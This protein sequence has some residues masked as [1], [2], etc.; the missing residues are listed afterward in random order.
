MSDELMKIVKT[1]L[2]THIA[3][4]P[5]MPKPKAV[6]S[7][8]GFAES[9]ID[10][11]VENE[12]DAMPTPQSNQEN[13]GAAKK[14]RGKTKPAASKFSKPKA[15]AP[16]RRASGGSVAVTKKAPPK[17]KAAPKRAPLNEQTN[18]RSLS[19]TEEVDE[20]D[21][22]VPQDPKRRE[23]A[24]ELL[25]VKQP[26]KRGRKPATRTTKQAELEPQQQAKIT[27][28]DGE[29]EY[30]PTVVRQTK[31]SKKVPLAARRPAVSK[32]QPSAEPRR[33]EVIPETQ[34]APMGVDTSLFPEEDHEDAMPQSVFRPTG[35][36]PTNPG[37]R[38]APIARRRAGS[39]SDTER[40]AS[41]P[42]IRRKL[43]DM[44]KKFENLD[45]KYRNLR[46]V[47][48]KEAEA[49]FERLK[50]TSEAKAKG[51]FFVPDDSY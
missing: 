30:T 48:I 13:A 26:A 1:N 25:P 16:S 14:G 39:A 38:Q 50:T 8:S 19:D 43:G 7:L 21:A 17:K 32:R 36:R 44:T 49:N 9:D 3:P 37:I 31:L 34:E 6:A 35:D 28:K 42:A 23:S 12:A 45:M 41:D 2:H 47:G 33:E 46:E 18:E 11:E 10:M 51:I 4:L 40:T 15:K 5:T 24:D 20:F 29:F 27:E 22:A